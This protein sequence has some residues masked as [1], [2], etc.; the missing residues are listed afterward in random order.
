MTTTADL[1]EG[2]A[3]WLAAQGVGVYRP[4][5]VHPAGETA[6]TLK[7]LPTAPDRAV[8][9]NVYDTRDDL[10]TPLREVMVQLRFRAPG[11]LTAVDEFADS[12]F[13]LLH[14]RHHFDAG[15]VR[16]QRAVRRSSAPMGAD[17]NRR[18]ERADNY[19]L[20][21]QRS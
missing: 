16:V 14:M 4:D 8:A 19:A 6:V 20:I 7:R 10:T 3:V 17:D 13:P 15:T 5:S 9:V 21:L 12:V 18:E 1:L 11:P 2:V